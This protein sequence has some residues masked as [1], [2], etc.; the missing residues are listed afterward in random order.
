M[1][2]YGVIAT[3]VIGSSGI[4]TIQSA[5]AGSDMH[6]NMTLIAPGSVGGGND[7][8]A[9]EQQQAMSQSGL[10]ANVQ[11]VNVPGAGGTI[12]L[13]QLPAMSGQT[14]TLLGI[15]T[16]MLGAIE[17]NDSKV[18][19]SDVTPISRVAEEY[20]VLVA[21]ADAPYDSID[22]MIDVW[23]EDPKAFPFTGGS[24]G[25]IDQLLIAQLALDSGIDAS[26]ITYIPQTG[27][28]EAV[29]AILAGTA[30]VISTGYSEIAD[31]I[32]AGKVKALG[33][34]APEPLE[35]VDIPTFK[36]QGYPTSLT[37]WRG[38]AAPP[39]IS[40]A[41][42]AE[43]EHLVRRAAQTPEWQE[44]LDRLYWNDVYMSG[45]EFDK[46]LKEDQAEI[47]DLVKELDL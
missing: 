6:A 17:L 35:G 29:Q 28:G 30:Q 24:A 12:G 47:A 39:G 11:V 7:T 44:T 21:P 4:L 8:F 41:E 27:G 36:E 25:S 46:F 2:V 33:I 34:A 20:N 19:L 31:Q 37:N 18:D 42:R 13:S 26:D 40:D 14:N 10:V 45:P 43:L 3:V 38:V 9:R 23:K 15:G 16:V 5:N 32:E 22:E 1:I